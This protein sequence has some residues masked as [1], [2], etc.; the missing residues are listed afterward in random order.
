MLKCKWVYC[1]YRA[2]CKGCLCSNIFSTILNILGWVYFRFKQ[3]AT[4]QERITEDTV[5]SLEQQHTEH[6]A[7]KTDSEDRRP[8]STE[9]YTLDQALE[10]H[11]NIC[12]AL[13][14]VRKHMPFGENYFTTFYLTA[15]NV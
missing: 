10:I 6:M 7:K 1:I 4:S 3:A 8:L 14:R 9:E 2:L 12:I 13:L 11:L 5:L 15:D